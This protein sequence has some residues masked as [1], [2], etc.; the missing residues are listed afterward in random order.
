MLTI[1]CLLILCVVV[2]SAVRLWSSR[3]RTA[4]AI[5]FGLSLALLLPMLVADALHSSWRPPVG[6]I[7]GP[8]PGGLVNG[9]QKF[10]GGLPNFLRERIWWP[11]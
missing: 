8:I 7:S 10:L 1:S 3:K 9:R 11:D 5:L 6:P 2:W 4:W